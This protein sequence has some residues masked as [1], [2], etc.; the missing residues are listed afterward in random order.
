[1][2]VRRRGEPATSPMYIGALYP[3]SYGDLFDV[4]GNLAF[5]VSLHSQTLEEIAQSVNE[6]ELVFLFGKEIK[7]GE[8]YSVGIV[9]AEGDSYVRGQI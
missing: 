4:E 8:S 3:L 9:I 7:E 1:M 6:R 2:F 5:F